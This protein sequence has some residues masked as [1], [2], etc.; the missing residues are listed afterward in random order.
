MPSGAEGVQVRDFNGDGHSDVVFSVLQT[1]DSNYRA[2]SP[3]FLGSPVGWQTIPDIKFPTVGARDVLVSDL[4]KDGFMDVVFAQEREGNDFNTINS[5][6]FWGSA[7]GWNSTADIEFKTTGASGVIAADV[8][9]DGL[10]DLVFANYRDNVGTSVDSMIFYQDANGFC[11]TVPGTYLPTNGARA[12]AAGDI[13]GDTHIDLVFANSLSGGFSEID[14]YIY[15]GKAGGGFDNIPD[16][17]ATMGAQDVVVADVTGSGNLDV[18]FACGFDNTPNYIVDSLMYIGDGS[19]GFSATPVPFPTLGA[20]GVKVTDLDGTGWKDLVFSCR[21]DGATYEIES[22]V[23]LGGA[24]GFSG[25]PDIV[26]PTM[27]ASDVAVAHLVNKDTGGYMSKVIAPDDWVNTGVF[28]TFKYT[29][30]LGAGQSGTIFVLDSTTGEVLAQTD[31]LS[32]SNEW[33]L[34]DKF[35]VREHNAIQI[36]ITSTGLGQGGGFILDDLWLNWSPRAR[37]PPKVVDMQVSDTSVL[38]TRTLDMSVNVSDEYDFMSELTIRIEHRLTNT[39]SPWTRYMF[40]GLVYSNDAWRLSIAPRVDVEV[41]VYDVRV[42]V[43]DGDGMDSGWVLYTEVFEVRNN[44]PSAPEVSISPA[45]PVATSTLKADVIS[46]AT[47]VES[48]L[49]TY[50]YTWYLDGTL[51]PDLTTYNIA[52][53]WLQRGQNWSVEVRAD[54][55]DDLGPPSVAWRV[56]QNAGPGR[57]DDLPDPMFEEDTPDSDWLDLSGAFEDPDGDKLTYRVGPPAKHLTIDIDPDTG[58]VTLTPDE[59]WNGVETVVFWASDGEFEVNQTVTITVTAVNDQPRF[60]TINGQPYTGETIVMVIDQ[61]EELSIMI[62]AL[63]VEGDD[64]LF[65]ID[66][67]R[68]S[69]DST[70]GEVT[71][72]PGNDDVG[73]LNFTVSLFDNVNPSR[74]VTVTFNVEILNINDQLDDP[75]IISPTD[76]EIVKWNQSIGLRG[77]CTDPDEI[78]GQVLTYTWSSNGSGLLGHGPSINFRFTDS[79]L[80]NITLTVTDGE[81]TKEV[82]VVIDVGEKPYVPPYIP[83]V[84]ED[85]GLSL[86]LLL[87]II[88]AIVVAL[89]LVLFIVKRR[90]TQAEEY[91]PPAPTPEEERRKKM[92]DFAEAVKD[93]ADQME[94]ER[95]GVAVSD[96][97]E[98]TGTG[99]TP[100]IDMKLTETTSDETAKLWSGVESQEPVIDDAEMEA[101]KVENLKRKVQSSI[102]AMPYGIPAPELRHISPSILA[103]EV[104]TGAKHNLPDGLMLV[105]I[106]GKWY[107]GDHEDSSNFLKPYKSAV[108]VDDGGSAG[109]KSS[110]W[111]EE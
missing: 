41:G 101:L 47:D 97:I 77:V 28:E 86:G 102:E 111:E 24:S 70:T 7:D 68:A 50:T 107:H 84:T 34:A 59:N 81:Y 21:Y 108:Q 89:L 73:W 20:S 58:R 39:T 74:K 71:Y 83:P 87:G 52:S 44:L 69:I 78:Y 51:M 53:S 4:D 98:L 25:T 92:E 19:G 43:V 18:V 38:R 90:S 104:A 57:A 64:L 48:N 105:T 106:R 88:A 37:A 95:D 62:H 99:M 66:P 6:L 2:D 75:R 79:G 5:T 61:G 36:M 42:M 32:G 110:E 91:R 11:G 46:S 13:D 109:G 56:I 65:S 26:V 63:D 15:W 80:H 31:L 67:K 3:M 14:S 72:L 40:V 22:Q 8:D 55:G 33:S 16:R 27:G 103:E 17:L 93:T 35:R 1:S 85:D 82:F 49:L 10:E 23:Y 9:K 76:M 94:A 96:G 30:N 54:D 45:R 60:L 100:T 12:V 29:A